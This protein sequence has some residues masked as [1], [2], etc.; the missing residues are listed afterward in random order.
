MKRDS[1]QDISAK[2][3]LRYRVVSAVKVLMLAGTKR[4][5]AI[6]GVAEQVHPDDEGN[7]HRFSRRTVQ[8]WVKAFEDKGIDGLQDDPHQRCDSSVVLKPEFLA[9]LKDQKKEDPRASIPELIR[10]ARLAGAL[11]PG[12]LVDR[13][14]VWRALKRMGV[15]TRRMRTIEVDD[16]RRFAFAERMQMVLV[17]F[18][19]FRAGPTRARRLAIYF[20]DDA[21]RFGLGVLVGT[22]GE[23]PIYYLLSLLSVLRSYGLMAAVYMDHGPAFIADDV[24]SV[25]RR[26]GVL[27]IHGRSEY[28]EGHGLCRA[29][30][31]PCYAQLGIMCTSPMTP[32]LRTTKQT[33]SGAHNQSVSRKARIRLVARNRCW[34]DDGSSRRPRAAAFMVMSAS[35]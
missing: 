12:E 18:K 24:V 1:G 4:S 3:L 31:N 6:S 11:H 33:E 19:H 13:T 21:T 16:K 35:K 9:Y 22:E 26:L 2:M 5:V 29:A 20:L 30:H 17:D 23:K 28:P 7:V 15:A 34:L 32:L 14:T 8:R 27:V 10:R 25:L